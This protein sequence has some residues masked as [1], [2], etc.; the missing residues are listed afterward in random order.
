MKAGEQLGMDFTRLFLFP[1]PSNPLSFCCATSCILLLVEDVCKGF[2]GKWMP[3]LKPVYVP[4]SRRRW[5]NFSQC[6][7]HHQHYPPLCGQDFQPIYHPNTDL[8]LSISRSECRSTMQSVKVS[9][10][11]INGHSVH[12]YL[13]IYLILIRISQILVLKWLLLPEQHLKPTILQKIPHFWS[14]Q[15][16]K[17]TF[18]WEQYCKHGG[19][20]LL[21]LPHNHGNDLGNLWNL[22]TQCQ[23]CLGKCRL[24]QT[25]GTVTRSMYN[26]TLIVIAC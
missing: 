24:P 6:V 3:D 21:P 9:I 11:F 1:S 13:S 15:Q 5:T 16:Q 4:L 20:P 18:L 17:C 12:I 8:L 19:M 2:S 22:P 7:P 14:W 25:K 23:T 10:K 26:N